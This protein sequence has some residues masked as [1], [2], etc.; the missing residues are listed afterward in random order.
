MLRDSIKT[1][2]FEAVVPPLNPLQDFSFA[3]TRKGGSSRQKHVRDDTKAPHVA[4]L[5]VGTTEDFGCDVVGGPHWNGQLHV[6]PEMTGE[7]KVDQLEVGCWSVVLQEEVLELQVT[8]G[9]VVVMDV[10]NSVYHGF[11]IVAGMTLGVVE[12]LL[13]VEAVEHLSARAELK[14]EV[15]VVGS[16]INFLQTGDVGVVEGLE[17]LN[18]VLELPHGTVVVADL[19]QV[20]CL[21]GILNLSLLVSADPNR[22]RDPCAQF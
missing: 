9:D 19:M 5:I 1:V 8:V 22:P 17:D 6:R 2:D 16:L 7:A 3:S 14:D 21:H 12:A 18:F 20:E 4:T 11:D 15:D 13:A 10:S